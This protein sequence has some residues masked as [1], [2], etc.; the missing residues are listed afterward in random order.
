MVR[1]VKRGGTTL[2]NAQLG[3]T[4]AWSQTVTFFCVV[5]LSCC[6]LLTLPILGPEPF[7]ESRGA[8]LSQCVGQDKT[9][10]HNC[11]DC[12]SSEF[13]I[14]LGRMSP[15]HQILS[16][17]F[18]QVV[19]PEDVADEFELQQRVGI[20]AWGVRGDGS[21]NEVVHDS[22]KTRTVSCP[23]MGSTEKVLH[24]R[25]FCDEYEVFTEYMVGFSDYDLEIHLS[26][27]TKHKPKLKAPSSNSSLLCTT[28]N[29]N[30][31]S[32]SKGS[33]PAKFGWLI[34]VTL[35][36]VS[37]SFTKF[38]VAVKAT[39]T[40]VSF[41]VLVLY[42]NRLRKIPFR[43]RLLEQ[44]W[45]EL[46][47]FMLVF[48]N[49]PFVSAQ[50]FYP[51]QALIVLYILSFNTFMALIL[52]FWLWLMDHIRSGQGGSPQADERRSSAAAGAVTSI[53][54]YTSRHSSK[55]VIT[56]SVW[57]TYNSLYVFISLKEKEDPGY[58]PKQD[59]EPYWIF[60]ILF[61]VLSIAY[62]IWLLVLVLLLL[63]RKAPL[64][65]AQGYLVILSLCMI[66]CTIVYR[67]GGSFTVPVLSSEF[68]SF[69]A[70]MN[71]YMYAITVL[72]L[73]TKVRVPNKEL[74]DID[75]V[76]VKALV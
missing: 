65:K 1:R 67:A 73:P 16:V 46:L 44:N 14:H 30:F 48:F 10:E 43:Q 40:V 2:Q 34:H 6:C 33:S 66:T 20:R 22:V 26:D 38:E 64:G 75:S 69:Q 18:K 31:M 62:G 51:L 13:G 76:V 7:Q 49:D 53:P 27:M 11:S 32:G 50:V 5:A 29:A 71:A 41:A 42:H 57:I 60:E 8:W 12:D 24:S 35:R 72:Y 17:S 61:G 4:F 63:R 36:F 45:I 56:L 70:I 25:R 23:A 28:K 47:L 68:L 15:Q 54:S 55:S 37:R 19:H 59:F 52:L 21:R 74:V 9:V 39:L 3:S 58:D